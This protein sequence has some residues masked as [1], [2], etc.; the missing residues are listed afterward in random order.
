[1]VDTN[2]SKSFAFGCASS[3]LARATTLYSLQIL[4]QENKSDLPSKEFLHKYINVKWIKKK[5]ELV[6]RILEDKLFESD[7]F[8]LKSILPNIFALKN[9]TIKFQRL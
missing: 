6:N 7:L 3:S 2:D 9:K 5:P 8:H 4:N 1:M